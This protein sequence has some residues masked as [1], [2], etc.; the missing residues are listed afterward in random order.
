MAMT[1]RNFGF[2]CELAAGANRTVGI[3]HEM[4]LVADEHLHA[5]HCNCGHCDPRTGYPL[6]AQ[7]D[8]TCDGEII[9][10]IL[11]HGSEQADEVI[12]GLAL[13]LRQAKA[14]PDT[15]AGFHVHVERPPDLLSQVRTERIFLRYQR[16]LAELA[17]ASMSDVRDYNSPS[18]VPQRLTPGGNMRRW[19]DDPT[20][21]ISDSEDQLLN[22]QSIGSKGNWLWR[23]Y[24]GTFEFRLWNSTIA[25]W[26]MRLAVGMS[27]A[28]VDAAADGVNVTHDD[29]RSLEE[30]VGPY[31]DDAAWAGV[32][33]QRHHKGGIAK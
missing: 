20:F 26:R 16:D 29:P 12:G 31:M 22:L 11:E 14:R 28:I 23:T 6:H 7:S 30:V 32:L 21:W 27:V 10:R 3:L 9:T 4:G 33:R 8:C 19:E 5:Y 13:A 15:N 1:G 25:E 24:Y 18:R 17:S 2:E